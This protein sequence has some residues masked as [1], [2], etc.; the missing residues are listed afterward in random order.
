MKAK[1]LKKYVNHLA[2]HFYSATSQSTQKM[3]KKTDTFKCYPFSLD[4]HRVDNVKLY[5]V[6]SRLMGLYKCLVKK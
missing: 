3:L 6:G 1:K 4:F 5:Y 2:C